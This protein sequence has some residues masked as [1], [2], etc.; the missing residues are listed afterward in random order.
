MEAV[1]VILEIK[2]S[3]DMNLYTVLRKFGSGISS[4]I[5]SKKV[6]KLSHFSLYFY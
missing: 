1:I 2:P 4:C 5:E 3:M 6:N